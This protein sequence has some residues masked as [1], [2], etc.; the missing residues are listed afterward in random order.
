MTCAPR[1]A[2]WIRCRFCWRRSGGIAS[3]M[4]VVEQ[5]EQAQDGRA[6]PTRRDMQRAALH[7]LVMLATECATREAEIDRQYR[8]A[9]EEGEKKHQWSLA[10]LARKLEQVKGEIQ[11]R[12]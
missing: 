9:L 6:E 7:D 5:A 4:S 1:L 8:A 12:H 3:K 11:R 2:R 10:D